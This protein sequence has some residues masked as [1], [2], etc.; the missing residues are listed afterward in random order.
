MNSLELILF[1]LALL[2]IIYSVVL[3]IQLTFYYNKFKRNNIK[4]YPK[5]V[6][7]G[8]YYCEF[9]S[10][11]PFEKDLIDEAFILDIKENDRGEA[12][13]KYMINNGSK[14]YTKGIDE[15]AALYKQKV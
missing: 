12:Y 3:F 13:V 10:D 2:S 8:K 11:N 7:G 14:T 6:I 9:V 1:I 15:F 5:Y 4:D